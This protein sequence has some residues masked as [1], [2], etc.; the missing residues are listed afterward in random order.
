[1]ESLMRIKIVSLLNLLFNCAPDHKSSLN[2][3]LLEISFV[4]ILLRGVS[5]NAHIN[6]ALFYCSEYDEKLQL[7]FSVFVFFYFSCLP[8]A[9]WLVAINSFA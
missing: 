6:S 1:M 7:V 5:F 8:Y 9:V 2:E 4:I 3:S